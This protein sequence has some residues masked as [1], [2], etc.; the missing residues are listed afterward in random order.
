MKTSLN[1]TD[2]AKYMDTRFEEALQRQDLDYPRVALQAAQMLSVDEVQALSRL[3]REDA[4]INQGSRNLLELARHALLVATL[5][6]DTGIAV[7]GEPW[8]N[9]SEMAAEMTATITRAMVFMGGQTIQELQRAVAY[10]VIGAYTWRVSQ[11]K[12]YAFSL[13]VRA[14]SDIPREDLAQM[15]R[16][17]VSVRFLGLMM[18]ATLW[19]QEG[20][21]NP[22][23]SAELQRMAELTFQGFT[24]PSPETVQEAAQEQRWAERMKA[25]VRVGGVASAEELGLTSRE[26]AFGTPLLR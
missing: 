22:V 23:K 18:N 25:R 8:D 5:A 4:Q 20:A 14:M 1:L 19:L 7:V 11:A 6:W 9:P 10:E 12:R 21:W 13:A 16:N 24:Q 26:S 17:A 2:A 15:G 3:M